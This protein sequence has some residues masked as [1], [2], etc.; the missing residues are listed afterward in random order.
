MTEM[1]VASPCVR[2]CCLDDEDVCLGCHRTVTEIMAWGSAGNP[3]RRAILQR[4]AERAEA[5]R[6]RYPPSFP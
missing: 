2:N 6:R 5:R 3:E 1:P 4:A